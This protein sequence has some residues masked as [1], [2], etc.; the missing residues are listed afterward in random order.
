MVGFGR[1]TFMVPIPAAP[2]IGRVERKAA[3]ALPTRQDARSCAAPTARSASGCGWRDGRRSRTCRRRR[4]TPATRRTG[5]VSQA[6]VRYK[7]NDYSVP[8][9]Y[10]HRDVWVKG[11]VDAVV[12]GCGG[13]IVARHPRCYDRDDIVFDPLH[14]LALIEKKVGALDQAAP[15]QGWELP[16]EFPTLRRLLEAR[17][18]KAGRRE[19]VQVLRLLE[20]FPMAVVHGA[21]TTRCGSA[22]IGY[23]AVKHLVLCRVERRPPK[24]DLDVYPYLPRGDRRDDV[25]GQLHEPA[26]RRRA[27]CR[28]DRHGRGARDPAAPPSQEAEAAD[29]AARVRE[30]GAPVRGRER[31]PR[32]LPDAG[33]SN[34]SCSTARRAWSS[35][36]SRRAR[37]PAVKSLDSFDFDAI[38][39]L[40]KKQ[41]LDLARCELSSGARTSS[42]SAPA[43]QARPTSLWGSGWPPARGGCRSASPPPPPSCT[44]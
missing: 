39:G 15:L 31:R 2:D 37:F 33:W 7:S 38:P 9:A 28:H 20:T 29:R 30:A 4:S 44:S 12:I 35:A 23:D 40:N 27:E 1:R 41:V 11:Y 36:A 19:Y 43:A 10:A 26:G 3:G 5:R 25:G 34:W 32:P 17:L 13:E 16:E 42:P 8:V 22:R 18:I 21:V 6:L 14:Y 24:L